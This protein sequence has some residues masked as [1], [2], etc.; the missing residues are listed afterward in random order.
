MSY[1]SIIVP[2]Y[3]QAVYLPETLQSVLD[4]SYTDWECIIVDDGSPDNTEE[5]AAEWMGKDDR[6]KYLKAENGGVAKARN[7]GIELARGEWILPLDSDDIIA[8]DYLK[9]AV[10][11]M[12]NRLDVGIIYCKVNF[13]GAKDGYW[14]LPPFEMKKFLIRNQIFNCGF[15]KKEDWKK[16]GGYDES[17]LSGREDWEFWIN[18]LKT[19]GKEVVR[20]DYL[21]FFYR[22]K[23]VSRNVDFMGD[24]AKMYETESRIYE[25]HKDLYFKYFGSAVEILAENERLVAENK[26]LFQRLNGIENLFIYKL[27]KRIASLFGI[28]GY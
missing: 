17:M 8:K 19:T 14:D 24:E 3:N 26:E 18:L 21:G 25:K 11:V 7:N 23:E 1:I 16:V 22:I 12:N 5:V 15:F 9:K 10:E 27:L 2:C 13:F 4:Q 28:K 20:L 6:F